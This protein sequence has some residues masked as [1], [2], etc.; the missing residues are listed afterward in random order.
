MPQINLQSMF[1]FKSHN[2]SVEDLLKSQQ[3]QEFLKN[4]KVQKR[5]DLQGLQLEFEVI[6]MDEK[7]T[8]ELAQ[9]VESFN[10]TIAQKLIEYDSLE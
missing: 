4:N 8:Q 3:I 5:D 10:Q 6:K 7:Y 2:K 9:K 1:H